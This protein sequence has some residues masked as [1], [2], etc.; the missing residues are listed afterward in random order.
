M[1]LEIS[2]MEQLTTNNFIINKVIDNKVIDC[3]GDG[4]VR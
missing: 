4:R 2:E 1:M 3:R